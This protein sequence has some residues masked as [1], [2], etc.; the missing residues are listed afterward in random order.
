MAF[1]A[2]KGL[3][4]Y[5]VTINLCLCRVLGEAVKPSVS[6]QTRSR[7]EEIEEQIDEMIAAHGD[8]DKEFTSKAV[9]RK[10]NL[11]ETN[12][13]YKEKIKKAVIDQIFSR[14]WPEVLKR[15][16]PALKRATKS[17]EDVSRNSPDQT[18]CNISFDDEL[19]SGFNSLSLVED[20]SLNSLGLRTRSGRKSALSARKNYSAVVPIRPVVIECSIPVPS[21]MSVR[22]SSALR[23]SPAARL[24]Q[25]SLSV[26]LPSPER[27]L[28]PM[29][30]QTHVRTA[31]KSAGGRK[32]KVTER[33][34]QDVRPRPQYDAKTGR[35]ICRDE[36][37]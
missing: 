6:C 2:K 32:A 8:Y 15:I 35:M 23:R 36:S 26:K 1:G 4:F 10:Q 14:I 16:E 31:V 13:I 30:L 9:V 22:A 29:V 21:A 37:R 5:I 34:Q 27:L 3:M 20:L 19:T 7:H 12:E 11:V 33:R 18:K 25:P 24:S 17:H 28:S